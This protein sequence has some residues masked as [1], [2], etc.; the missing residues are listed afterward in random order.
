MH[1]KKQIIK[2]STFISWCIFIVMTELYYDR[3]CRG[4]SYILFGHQ[5]LTCRNIET[6]QTP[7]LASGL[8]LMGYIIK[9]NLQNIVGFIYDYF[10][11]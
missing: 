1:T 10:F 4:F 5:S 3:Y 11:D 2:I 9:K 8:G 6:Y 7:I